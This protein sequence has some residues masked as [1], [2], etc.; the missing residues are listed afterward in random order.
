GAIEAAEATAAKALDGLLGR[1][2]RADMTVDWKRASR[3]AAA[4]TFSGAGKFTLAIFLQEFGYALATRDPLR[5]EEFFDQVA[6]TDFYVEYGLFVAG[7]TAGQA[8]YSLAYRKYLRPFLKQ[9]LMHQVLKSQLSLAAGLALPQLVHG[10]FDGKTFVISLGSLG[11]SSTLVHASM[12][13]IPWVRKITA[14]KSGLLRATG[15][16][17][18]AAELA[19]VLTASSEIERF[20]HG[21]LDR[22]AAKRALA[23]AADL[24]ARRLKGASSATEREQALRDYALAWEHYRVHLYTP[25]FAA[26]E[27]L[28]VRL[29]PALEGVMLDG[30]AADEALERTTDSARLNEYLAEFARRRREGANGTSRIEQAVATFNREFEEGLQE[31]YEDNRRDTPFIPVAVLGGPDTPVG[32]FA[33]A[34]ASAHRK[35][36]DNRLETYEDQREALA[37]LGRWL[38]AARAE[39]DAAD[40]VVTGLARDDANFLGENGGLRKGIAEQVRAA[41]E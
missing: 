17:Y 27:Q 22:R 33:A 25:L 36:S 39:V 15:W 28:Q 20:V 40:A 7:A 41:G 34:F 38:A 9:G 6:S 37:A 1:Y 29:E 13:R 21:T 24:V 2:R 3:D 26:Q 31:V 35:V 12:S 30:Q 18:Q 19:I 16:V 10:T 11:I 5:L 8:G 32:A 14:A 4:H 23:E